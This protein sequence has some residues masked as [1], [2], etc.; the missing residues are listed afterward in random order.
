[1]NSFGSAGIRMALVLARVHSLCGVVED[2]PQGGWHASDRAP[3]QSGTCSWSSRLCRPSSRCSLPATSPPP[4][5]AAAQPR[6]H[7]STTTEESAK[8][9]WLFITLK[10][11]LSLIDYP[12]RAAML[13]VLLCTLR[14]APTT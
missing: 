12:C 5:P 7:H 1:M 10:R 8:I 6:R 11:L 4:P 14:T 2:I 3:A 9:D 13:I